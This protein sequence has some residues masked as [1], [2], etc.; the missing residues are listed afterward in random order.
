MATAVPL[1]NKAEFADTAMKFLVDGKLPPDVR[2]AAAWALGMMVVP[3]S[4]RDF[5]YP[6]VA[7]AAG[8][9]A[10]DLGDRIIAVPDKAILRVTRLTELLIQIHLAFNGQPGVR[11]SGL[12]HQANPAAASAQ[13]YV[14]EVEKRVRALTRA[15]LALGQTVGTNIPKARKE[16]VAA[17]DDLRSFLAKP[18]TGARTLYSGG[19]ESPEPTLPAKVA[20]SAR[21]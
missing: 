19:P 17:V 3:N 8:L 4:V 5:N 21:P 10:A 7:Y 12:L 14:A 9:A 1:G 15:S 18:P 11:E 6:L 2:S 16:V 20:P 13:G